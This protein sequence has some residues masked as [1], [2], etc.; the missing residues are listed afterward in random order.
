M[1]KIRRNATRQI[2]TILNGINQVEYFVHENNY[3]GGKIFQGFEGNDKKNIF[4]SIKEGYAILFENE[5]GT[6]TIKMA[7]RCRWELS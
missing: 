2:E 6:H 7:G 4:D 5:N 3:K 1:K